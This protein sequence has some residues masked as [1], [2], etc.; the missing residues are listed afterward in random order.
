LTSNKEW[1]LIM[2]LQEKM[3][4]AAD[5]IEEMS[6]QIGQLQTMIRDY[7]GLRDRVDICEGRLDRNDAGRERERGL[8]KYCWEKL[9]YITGVIGAAAALTALLYK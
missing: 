7:N 6:M 5:K 3:D 2:Q 4:R 1:D 8:N 9:G